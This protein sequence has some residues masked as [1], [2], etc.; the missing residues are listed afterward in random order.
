MQAWTNYHSHTNYCDGS[1]Q[2]D[3][4]IEE[5]IKNNLPAYGFSSH[6]PVNFPTNWCIPDKSIDNYLSEIQ[7][8]KELNK[9]EIEVYLGLEIDFIPEIAGRSKHILSDIS[10]DYFISSIHF[11]DTFED[12]TPWNIDTSYELFSNGLEKI[13]NN[14]IRKAATRFFELTRQMIIE[15]QP[16]IIGHIDKIKMFNV[17]GNYFRESEKWYTEQVDLT[18]NTLKEYNTI[19]EIN[20]R[21]YYRYGQADLYPGEK[22][23]KKLVKA[24]IPLMI[25]SDAHK[26]DEIIMGMPYAAKI[27]KKFGVKS[28]YVLRS[29]KWREFPFDERG[30]FWK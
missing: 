10:L 13:F 12:G 5:A 1:S 9:D 4:Y 17:K 15:E 3:R 21:G 2:P 18:I 23:L 7:R 14:N 20:T 25:N 30:I 8:I 11:V 27:L 28:I 6:A 26:P 22:I 19:V 24:N 29:G 16:D